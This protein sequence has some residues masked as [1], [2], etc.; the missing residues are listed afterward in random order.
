MGFY[1]FCC[2][3]FVCFVFGV[4]FVCLFWGV[5][6]K[7]RKGAVVYSSVDFR[8]VESRDV[9]CSC[10]MFIVYLWLKLVYVA[11]LHQQSSQTLIYVQ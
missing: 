7:E 3:C 11:D 5:G 6:G 2:C 4:F 9:Q 8:G 1:C 10:T